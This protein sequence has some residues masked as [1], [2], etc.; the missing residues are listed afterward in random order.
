[1]G[2]DEAAEL[3][4][5]DAALWDS[6]SGALVSALGSFFSPLTFSP[7]ISDLSLLTS[8]F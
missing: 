2:R 1:L 7:L 5:N 3:C 8:H 4:G 6:K